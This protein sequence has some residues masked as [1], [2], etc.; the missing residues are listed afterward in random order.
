MASEY[1]RAEEAGPL[2]PSTPTARHDKA[3]NRCVAALA[4]RLQSA[5]RAG[6]AEGFNSLKGTGIGFDSLICMLQLN[7][8]L[9]RIIVGGPGWSGPTGKGVANLLEP[10]HRDEDIVWI[11]DL[12]EN[13]Q[14]WCVP[15]RFVRAP[16]NITWGRKADSG[17]CGSAGQNG[18][19]GR[20]GNGRARLN[21]P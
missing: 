6:R 17:Y 16:S 4:C 5:L 15:N 10:G 9:I 21:K 12:D 7:P 20:H 14:T 18:D 11:I 1:F 19:A 8:P 13:G 2:V 3:G